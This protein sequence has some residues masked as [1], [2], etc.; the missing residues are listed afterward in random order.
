MQALPLMVREVALEPG[1]DQTRVVVQPL[2]TA[3]KPNQNS[4]ST[5]SVPTVP[6]LRPSTG[7]AFRTPLLRTGIVARAPLPLERDSIAGELRRT[8]W[9][10]ADL[11]AMVQVQRW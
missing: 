4:A 7:L 3:A 6:V 9:R 2:G 8:A 10:A 11:Q 5:P 1:F